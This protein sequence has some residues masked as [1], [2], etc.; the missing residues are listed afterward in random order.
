MANIVLLGAPGA[1]KGTQAALIKEKYNLPHISTGD[2]F[3]KNIREGTPLGVQV[4]AIIDRGELVPDELTVALVKDRL[5]QPDCK[6]GYILDGFPRTIAQAEALEGF[7]KVDMAI[8]IAVENEAVIGRIAGRRMCKCGET[9]HVS[10]YGRE[11][12]AKCGSKL[13]QRD[14]DREEVVRERLRVYDEQTKPLIDFYA[15]RNLLRTVDG[16]GGVDATFELV[17][18]VIDGNR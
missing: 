16:S 3:R 17:C 9:Y 11:D 1:G 5:A 10:T 8:N 4:K 6:D 12:C 13:Y 15:N 2:I 7:S 18:K 14:D